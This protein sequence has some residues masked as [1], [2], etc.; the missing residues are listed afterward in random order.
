MTTK[1]K[2]C[3]TFK[4]NS[5]SLCFVLEIKIGI[6]IMSALARLQN[7]VILALVYQSW[8][9]TVFLTPIKEC[10]LRQQVFSVFCRWSIWNRFQFYITHK[11]LISHKNLNWSA[12]TVEVA[13][14]SCEYFNLNPQYFLL[15]T[16]KLI[17]DLWNYNYRFLILDLKFHS[18]FTALQNSC[19]V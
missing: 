6:K 13:V 19:F 12:I 14:V 11:K 3:L 10:Y 2:T 4:K 7:I 9:I 8:T 5:H 1:K 15:W 16:M 17:Y 18:Y